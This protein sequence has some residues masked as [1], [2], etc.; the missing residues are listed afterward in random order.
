MLLGGDAVHGPAVAPDCL[1]HHSSA[2]AFKSVAL[3]NLRPAAKLRFT[4][5]SGAPPSPW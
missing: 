2:W 4:N 5:G 1:A 3:Q